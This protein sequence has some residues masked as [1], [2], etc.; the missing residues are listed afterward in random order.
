MDRVKPSGRSGR[1]HEHPWVERF[2]EYLRAERG[3]S[4]HTVAAYVHDLR[5]LQAYVTHHGDA[6]ERLSYAELVG[7]AGWLAEQGYRLS[8]MGRVLSAVRSFF[9]FLTEVRVLPE[10]P[11]AFLAVPPRDRR[12]PEVLSPEDVDRLLQAIPLQNPVGCRDR[13]IVSLLYATGLRVSELVRLRLDDLDLAEGRLLCRGKGGR[14]RWLPIGRAAQVDLEK[15]LTTVRPR[16]RRSAQESALFL[17]RR[18]RPLSRV[19]VWQRLRHWARLAGLP[20]AVYPHRVRHTF[21]TH[22]LQ[23]GADLRTVQILLGHA[24]IGTT[25]VYTH[26]HPQ[27]FRAALNRHPLESWLRR[28]SPAD[29]TLPR[30]AEDPAC[31]PPSED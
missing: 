18:G 8:S 20:M 14:V 5:L 26:V 30:P 17:N 4:E 29:D 21:A 2:V 10:N 9:R 28:K 23:R 16:W 25:E 19:A 15:Y 6:W 22:L 1:A 13:A 11:A 7:F 24:S 27:R 31:R 12:L 3:Y